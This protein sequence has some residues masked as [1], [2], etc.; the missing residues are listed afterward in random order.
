MPSRLA[1]VFILV[2]VAIDSIGIGIIFP[3]MPALL[4]EVTHTDLASSALWGGVLATAFSAMQFLFGPLVGNLSDR[5]GR[6]PVMLVALATMALDYAVMALATSV[7]LLLAGRIVAGIAAATY[8]TAS[9]YVA[10]VSA[11]ETRAR[12][13]GLVGAAF[14]LG[15]VLG[16][17]LGGA[18]SLLGTRAPFW[19][20]AAIAAANLVVGL[21]A[22]PESLP[23]GRRRPFGW[24]RASP[25]ASFRAIGRLPGLR[26]YLAITFLFSVAFAAYPSVWSFFG[27]ERF[28]WDGW[29][30][31]I[32]LALFGVAMAATQTLLVGPAIRRWGETRTA[33][34]GMSVDVVAF[35]F[36]GFV[37]SGFWALVFTPVSALAG[38][39]GPALQALS[40]NA[41]PDDQQGEL[42]GVIAA[43]GAVAMA[44]APMLMTGTFWAF[45]APGAAVYAPGA[46]FLLSAVLMVA[47]VLVLVGRPRG[48]GVA[49]G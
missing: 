49:A 20:A 38:V 41:T 11:P 9:A 29:W 12:N 26:R 3:V 2:T 22:L 39:A 18:A 31:G 40:A 19:A 21:A 30:N 25:L 35:G 4:T 8:A 33:V 5:Y 1:L 14:G 43:V 16:P 28:G 46:P 44:L 15:F 24:R 48:A 23:A 37:T 7:W 13:F 36:Y 42:Q 45:T 32:S 6:R 17:L 27:T 34:Y 10:D 47:C